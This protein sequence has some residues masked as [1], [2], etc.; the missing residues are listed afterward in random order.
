MSTF[1][2]RPMTADD[3]PQVLA[4]EN[5]VHAAPWDDI[6]FKAEW[7]K[8]YSV[9]WVLTD[10]E[11][12]AQVVAYVVFWTM[13]EAFE[14]LNVVVSLEHRGAGFAKKM[15]RQ[16]ATEAI[17]GG[18]KRLILD[19]R[20]SNLPAVALYQ[21]CG[22]SITQVRKGFYSNGEDAYHMALELEGEKVDF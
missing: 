6:G 14:V 5:R 16:V 13:A 21:R 11:T 20:K 18:V 19:V 7:Q 15:L 3:L 9:S 10:D 22:F 12:D 8:P 17:R 2:L 1:S 4:I